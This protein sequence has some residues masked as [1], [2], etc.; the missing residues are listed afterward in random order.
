MALFRNV[1]TLLSVAEATDEGV[2]GEKKRIVPNDGDGVPDNAQAFRVF[3]DLSQE[4]GA[5]TP[6]TDAVL[7]TSHDGTAWVQAAKATQLTTNADGHELVEAA[8]LG[9]WV[10]ARTTLGG[11]TPPDHKA[12]V[13]L[14]SSAPFRLSNK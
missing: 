6:T 2:T 8:A 7:E 10:R 9:P 14:A 12:T 11:G 3:F 13:V 1:H 5:D 4:G